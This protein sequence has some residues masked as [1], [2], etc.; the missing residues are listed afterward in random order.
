MNLLQ[1]V[2]LA[3]ERAVTGIA[4]DPAAAAAQVKPTQDAKHGD[5]QANCALALQ[6]VVG[7]SPREIAQRIVAALDLGDW[8]QPPEIAGPGFINLRLRDD[9]L[10]AQAR[11]MAADPRLRIDLSPTPKTYVIDYSSP[12]VA[13]PMHV[14]HLR[15]TII[16]DA[17]VRI[18]RHLGHKVVGDNHLG[19]W[20]TQ[21]GMILHGYKNL[22]D[23][24]RFK[25]DP[26]QE[27]ARLY[28]EVRRL[29]KTYDLLSMGLQRFVDRSAFADDPLSELYRGYLAAFQASRTTEEDDEETDLPN[30]VKDAYRKET[31]KLHEGDEENLALWREFMPHTYEALKRVYARLG[32]LPFDHQHGES[33]YHP[34][35][36]GVVEDLLA[37]GIAQETRGAIGI[38]L[39]PE[40]KDEA[41]ALIRKR[42]GA[43]TYTTSDLATIAYRAKEFAPD[44]VLYV[45]DFR[46]GQHFANLFE[47]ARRWGFTNV[48][49]EHVS[50]GSVLDPKTKRPIKTREGGGVSLEDLLDG[51][52]AE[53]TKVYRAG[54]TRAKEQGHEVVELTPE[55]ERDL[56]T[57]IGIGA[58]KYADLSQNRTIDYIFSW[59]KMLAM[60]GNTATYMQYAYARN[61]SIFRRGDEDVEAYRTD[62]PPVVITN[63]SERALALQLLRFEDALQA[64][65]AEFKPNLVTSYLWDLAKAYSTFFEQSDVLKAETPE[66]RKSRLVL[67][68]LTARVIQQGLCLLGI[69]TVE[70]M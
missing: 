42:D 37:K 63:A 4:P 15:S 62:P 39:R 55:Q 53:A 32:I 52:I 6:K 30:P 61:R 60:N 8:L 51:A 17:L 1:S 21:F 16:G 36:P 65:A 59:E 44:H 10:A 24:E 19:D 54:V 2:Q 35:L 33:F 23:A 49:F 47:I 5:Y 7:G 46:Q 13:K 29:E 28:L 50:F 20:G 57:V 18:L 48:S 68:D 27:L 41:P 45:V 64:A 66:L 31:A 26:V 67:C 70:R 40:K 38:F 34:M 3:V 14:G 69:Q 58:V 25:Q 9:W 11:K 12:N 22:A 56:A 43:F